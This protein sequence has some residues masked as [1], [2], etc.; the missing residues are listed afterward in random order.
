MSEKPTL[1]DEE[2]LDVS[3]AS[4]ISPILVGPLSVAMATD[5]PR[6]Q[7]PCGANIERKKWS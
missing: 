1:K 7:E 4:Q 3:G 6:F 5:T 2:R